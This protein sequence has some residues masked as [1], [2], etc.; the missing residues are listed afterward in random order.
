MQGSTEINPLHHYL[1]HGRDNQS[2]TDGH[3]FREVQ[4]SVVQKASLPGT[5]RHFSNPGPRFEY[6]MSN[7]AAVDAAVKCIAFFLPQFHE[8]DENNEW[9]GKGF[10]EWR[11]V[12]RGAPRFKEHY[13]PRIPRDLGFYN[14]LEGDVMQEQAALA[15]AN[16]I[17]AFC[18]YYYWF[19]LLYTSPSPRDATLSRMPSSA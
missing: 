2:P 13:Q 18:F 17:S 7:A 14:L 15:Q 16:G 6:P 19:C 10:T 3:T 8:F 9:W 5:L 4:E 11:N 12:S 1:L